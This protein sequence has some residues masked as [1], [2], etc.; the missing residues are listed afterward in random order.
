MGYFSAVKPGTLTL[1]RGIFSIP[2]Y[3]EKQ[4]HLTSLNR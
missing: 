4:G 2:S 1:A 3:P